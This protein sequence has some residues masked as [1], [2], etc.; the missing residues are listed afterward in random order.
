VQVPECFQRGPH[1][2]S[3]G[4][5]IGDIVR[6]RDRL[7]TGGSDLV[8]N[9]LRGPRICS[10]FSLSTYA[11]IVHDDASAFRRQTERIGATEAAPCAGYDHHSSV[12]KAWHRLLLT[13]SR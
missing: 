11:K 4:F 12:T 6:I 9:I 1:D 10:V 2:A 7:P 3:P 8:D 5:P 13:T